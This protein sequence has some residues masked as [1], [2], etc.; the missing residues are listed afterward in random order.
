MRWAVYNARARADADADAAAD[1]AASQ[2]TTKEATI[3]NQST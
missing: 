2:P 1:A 3:A